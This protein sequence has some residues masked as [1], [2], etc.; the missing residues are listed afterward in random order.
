MLRAALLMVVLVGC[1]EAAPSPSATPEPTPDA[2]IE[3]T[4]IGWDVVDDARGW[5]F[6]TVRN[7]S[8]E[9]VTAECTVTVSSEFGDT[10]TG[11]MEPETLLP[12]ETVN[13]RVAVEVG[14]G[15]AAIDSGEVRC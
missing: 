3:A 11:T 7:D 4:F 2:R 1:N 10:G 9:E 12:S 13:V 6:L 8:L 15:S 14:S 5:A